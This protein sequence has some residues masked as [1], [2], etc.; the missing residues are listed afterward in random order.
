LPVSA[1]SPEKMLRTMTV[2]AP[3]IAAFMVVVLLFE[4]PALH[5]S[6]R[7]PSLRVL[8]GLVDSRRA[9]DADEIADALVLGRRGEPPTYALPRVTGS[10]V[11][12]PGRRRGVRSVSTRSRAGW[13]HR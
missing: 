13:R 11:S 2:A 12:D 4:P 8:T 7:I 6:E 5:P 9:L 1:S 3:A 10:G